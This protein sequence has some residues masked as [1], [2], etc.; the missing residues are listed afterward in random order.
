LLCSPY[1][2]KKISKYR[3]EKYNK[4]NWKEYKAHETT[5][6][7]TSITGDLEKIIVGFFVHTR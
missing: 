3:N 5:N 7:T 2:T 6:E 4:P 1:L